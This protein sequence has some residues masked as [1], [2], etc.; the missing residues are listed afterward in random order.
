MAEFKLGELDYFEGQ[1]TASHPL[2]KDDVIRYGGRTYV[3]VTG[4]TSTTNFYDD[5]TNWNLFSDGTKWQSDWS[6]STFYKIN[7]IVRYGGIIYI[8]NTGHTAQATLEADQSKWDQFATSIDW[9]DNWVA[10]TV[11]KANDLVK[12]G[13]NIY[14]CNTGYCLGPTALGLEADI[15]KWVCSHWPKI[16]T[17]LGYQHK[18]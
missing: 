11:Y 9:K 17:R 10:G 18:I 16:E 15:L 12:Y 6:T 7:D 13:G 5:L 4:H 3:A 8:C 1:L 14:L 2:S